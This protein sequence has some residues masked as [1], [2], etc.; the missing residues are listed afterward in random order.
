MLCKKKKK[1]DNNMKKDNLYTTN[2][3]DKKNVEEKKKE[4]ISK[5][6]NM[7]DTSLEDNNK[8]NSSN[9]IKNNVLTNNSSNNI[10][11]NVLTNN[12]S[13]NIK[14]NVLT[15]N[16]SNNIK[17]NVLTNNSLFNNKKKHYL[18]N[19]DKTLLNK[20]IN[21]INYAYKNL[22][23]QKGNSQHTIN[24]NINDKDYDDNKKIMD[25][26]SIEKKKYI[27]KYI[28]NK[29]HMKKYNNNENKL[30]DNF[31]HSIIQDTF[32]NTSLQ[33]SNKSPLT[34]IKINNKGVKK[35]KKSFTNINKK[36]NNITNDNQNVDNCSIKKNN[37]INTSTQ[38]QNNKY[39]IN[40]DDKKEKSFKDCKK[41]LYKN[42][43]NNI[44]LKHKDNKK[45][46]ENSM[47]SILNH[48]EDIS[49]QK[50]NNLYNN[51]YIQTSI[52][53]NIEELNKY[54]LIYSKKILQTALIQITYK[55]NQ[56]QMKN[57]K[58]EIINNDQINKLNFNILTTRQQNNLQIMNANK[59]INSV[60]QIFNKIN[61]FAISNNLINILIKKNVETY[62]EKKKLKEKE[63]IIWFNELKTYLLKNTLALLAAEKIVSYIVDELIEDST[64][65]LNS[66]HNENINKIKEKIHIHK[67]ALHQKRKVD[68]GYLTFMFNDGTTTVYI[69][70]KI[71]YHMNLCALIKKIK[72]Y[73]NDKLEYI[74]KEYDIRTLCIKCKGL[75][76]KSI[77]E[78]FFSDDKEFVISMDKKIKKKKNKKYITT[79]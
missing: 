56:N 13:N 29:I 69:P 4:L 78:L 38:L 5:R 20:N 67:I 15:N 43:K 39:Q 62:N 76:I 70:T 40:V 53:Y 59:S 19:I 64:D 44:I 32:L 30:D 23:E 45:Y 3:V 1:I 50:N 60:L 72:Y 73:I 27:N 17:N 61:T 79:P 42:V 33:T 51:K 16:S 35:K 25:I 18:H 55:Q 41:E 49:I 75:K 37:I 47:Q 71:K 22:N 68:K 12:S 6:N 14:N 26:L 46:I 10:K 7:K 58:E 77:K 48:N 2:N 66:H 36:Y 21:C 24:V 54:S 65:N 31:V 57:K 9:N 52:I 74:K 63:K 34:S 11:N 28:P 8:N